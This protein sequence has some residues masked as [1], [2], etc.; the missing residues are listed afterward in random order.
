MK[1]DLR[2]GSR[3]SPAVMEELGRVVLNVCGVVP[4]GVVLFVPSYS[5]EEELYNFWLAKGYIERIE[6]VHASREYVVPAGRGVSGS[7]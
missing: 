1:L 5:Y 3:S 6:K 4:D 7:G 2:H